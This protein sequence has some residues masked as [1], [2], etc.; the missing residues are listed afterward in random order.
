M[1]EA[2]RKDPIKVS[3]SMVR[4]SHNKLKTLKL[5][6]E[7]F[8]PPCHE[9]DNAEDE[10]SARNQHLAN[11]FLGGTDQAHCNAAVDELNIN[12]VLG[13]DVCPADVPAAIMVLT[14]CRGHG[15]S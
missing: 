2:M 1:E 9:N 10:E 3:M 7:S 14:N 4:G 8:V 12:G 5:C 6:G 13:K 15:G 11:L